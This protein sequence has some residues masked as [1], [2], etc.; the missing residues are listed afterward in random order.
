[1]T[2]LPQIGPVQRGRDAVGVIG[3]GAMGGAM[4]QRLSRLGWTVHVHDRLPARVAAAV[5]AGCLPAADAAE[6]ARHCR[7][8]IVVV[9]DAAEAADALLGTGGSA[10]S[11]F[12]VSAVSAASA[13]RAVLLCPTIAPEEVQAL[14]HPLQTSGIG[15]LEAPMSGGPAR[16]LDATMSLMVAG[17][18][19]LRAELGP[20][21]ADLSNHVID[22]GPRLGDGSR[23][24]L[25][26]NLLATANLAAAAEAMDLAARVGLDPARTLEVI[27]R[28]SGQSWIADDRIGRWLQRGSED[29]APLAVRAR[30]ALLTKDSTLARRMAAAHEA[31]LPITGA[32]IDAFAQASAD[33]WAE[34][35][36]AHLLDHRSG[37]P[38]P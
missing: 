29:S 4:A 21:L 27:H 7:V 8:L 10:G 25:V 35:D 32:A 2:P 12:A 9:S 17:D 18:T 31:A 13:A 20:L 22:L 34:L 37:R 26:N 24:K 16:A 19:A 15:L 5:Q 28:S 3:V 30:I 14:A 23:M 36:D 33:G 38:R 1:M 11:A 6:L